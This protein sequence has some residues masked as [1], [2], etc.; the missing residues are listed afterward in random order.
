[1]DKAVAG[2]RPG[3]AEF[4]T[5]ALPGGVI[6]RVV[7]PPPPFR[8]PACVA[9]NGELSDSISR[10][11]G[12]PASG[13]GMGILGVLPGPV[14]RGLPVGATRAGGNILNRADLRL[15]VPEGALGEIRFSTVEF[16]LLLLSNPIRTIAAAE[17]SA[18][19]RVSHCEPPQS[20]S[21]KAILIL[22]FCLT[23]S[24]FLIPQFAFWRPDLRQ[25]ARIFK[26]GAKPARPSTPAFHWVALAEAHGDRRG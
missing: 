25:S 17:S 12:L 10:R 1:M 15:T 8:L 18:Q 7:T 5:R 20:S 3:E 14:P 4:S 22:D 11:W 6:P 2:E 19:E 23:R 24:A 13:E 9:I 26:T 16:Q 21:V